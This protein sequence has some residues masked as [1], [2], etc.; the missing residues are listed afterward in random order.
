MVGCFVGFAT[1]NI[2]LVL[3]N[4]LATK[5]KRENVI[6]PRFFQHSPAIFMAVAIVHH[7]FTN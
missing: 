1:A 4:P 5:A 3:A 6:P 2:G 7:I